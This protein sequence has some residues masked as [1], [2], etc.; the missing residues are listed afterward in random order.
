MHQIYQNILFHLYIITDYRLMRFYTL[1][2]SPKTHVQNSQVKQN[3]TASFI[4][5]MQLILLKPF[6][7]HVSASP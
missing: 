4:D 2:P 5:L 6:P 7:L 3:I 1:F